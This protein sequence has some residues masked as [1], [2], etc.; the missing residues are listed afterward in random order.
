MESFKEKDLKS[1]D[2]LSQTKGS[3][4]EDNSRNELVQDPSSTFITGGAGMEKEASE[5]GSNAQEESKLS[6]KNPESVAFESA[7]REQSKLS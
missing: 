6:E 4:K 7:G 3:L 2:G 1:V 5:V